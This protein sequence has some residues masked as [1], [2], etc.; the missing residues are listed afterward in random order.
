MSDRDLSITTLHHAPHFQRIVSEPISHTHQATPPLLCE[1][2][3]LS[4]RGFSLTIRTKTGR[5]GPESFGYSI[6]HRGHLLHESEGDFGTAESADRAARRLIDDA[7]GI[8][9]AAFP[10]LDEA[11]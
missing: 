5:F 9:D 3:T 2:L 6:F 7:I 4:H 11:A 1:V 8:Y 10:E